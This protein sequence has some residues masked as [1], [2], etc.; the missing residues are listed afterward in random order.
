[1]FGYVTFNMKYYILNQ[2]FYKKLVE[3]VKAC[4]STG[5]IIFYS[6]PQIEKDFKR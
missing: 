1:M 5:I 2:I 6:H 3:Y 4:T